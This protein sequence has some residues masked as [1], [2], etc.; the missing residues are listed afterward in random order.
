MEFLDI[1]I[2]I[3]PVFLMVGIGCLTRLVGILNDDS[4]KSVMGLVLFVLYPCFILWKVPGNE[5][6]QEVAIVGEAL[7]IGFLLTVLGFGVAW[8][9]GF[10]LNVDDN[11]GRN[12]FCL[13]AGLQN[14]GFVPIPLIIALF[15]DSAD[16][17]LGVLFIHN[18][19]LE[20]AL[21]TIGIIIVT[22]SMKGIIKRLINGPTVAITLGLILNFSGLHQ[23]IP[24]T[25]KTAIAQLGTCTIPISLILVGA[26]LTGVIQSEKWETKWR[27]IVGSLGAR[28]IFMPVIVLGTGVG[29]GHYP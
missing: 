29:G 1:L 14:Y 19:G 20:I 3:L 7:A 16:S 10:S 2:A 8:L 6:L 26:A 21:W 25:A 11:Q 28:F 12:T 13:S 18:L 27:V 9:I 23:Q 22:G 15:G 5:S 4:E 17:T 24:E